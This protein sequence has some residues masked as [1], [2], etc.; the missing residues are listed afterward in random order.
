MIEHLTALSVHA[1]YA[2]E[3]DAGRRACEKLLAMPELSRELDAQTRF[4]RT[5]YTQTLDELADC[6][7][8][9]LDVEP[10]EPG[11]STFNPTIADVDGLVAVVRS[12]NYRI[13]CGQY[14]M[15]EADGNRIRTKN[16]LARLR[17]DLTVS[18]CRVIAGPEYA[19]T[20]YPVEGL[21]DCRIRLT[22]AGVGVS[23]TIRNAAPLNGDCRIGTADLDIGRAELTNVKMLD[24]LSLQQHEKNWMP[25]QGHDAWVYA[26]NWDGFTVTTDADPALSGAYLMHRR[27][28]APQ[29]ASQFRGGS[30]AVKFRGGW[31]ALIH[32]VAHLPTKRVY[33]HRFV[34]FDPAMQLRRISPAFVFR[35]R[36]SIEFAAGL[37]VSGGSVIASFGVRDAEAWIVDVTAG[38]VERM[39]NAGSA[40]S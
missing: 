30:Q 25:V 31:L 19:A 18:D 36:Q 2:G 27:W 28:P 1:Y 34:W 13:E 3:L 21:E 8:V 35:E 38:D 23:A 39:L 32:E 29:L 5:F 4:N 20:D 15:P 10:A 40:H 11:W 16:L 37:V 22:P 33:E 12:S 24:C 14:V 7:F 26:C 6:R 9:R 17:P